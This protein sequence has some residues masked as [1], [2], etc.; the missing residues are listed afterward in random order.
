LALPGE[1]VKGCVASHHGLCERIAQAITQQAFDAPSR[2][3]ETAVDV[4]RRLAGD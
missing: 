3:T 1:L 4:F 2:R